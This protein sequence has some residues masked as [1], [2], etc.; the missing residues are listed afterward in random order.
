MS[1]TRTDD[2]LLVFRLLA[3]IAGGIYA[4]LPHPEDRRPPK[5]VVSEQL[6]DHLRGAFLRHR[7]DVDVSEDVELARAIEAL[8]GSFRDRAEPQDWR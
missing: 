5:R 1:E 4:G 6:M 3:S 8:A 2:D 7:P